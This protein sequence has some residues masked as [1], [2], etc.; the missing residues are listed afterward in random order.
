[1]AATV[2]PYDS[3]D[4]IN[5]LHHHIPLIDFGIMEYDNTSY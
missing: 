4:C 2:I 3:L 5:I 1:M